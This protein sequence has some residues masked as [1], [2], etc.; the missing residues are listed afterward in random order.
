METPNSPNPSIGTGSST[1][2]YMKNTSEIFLIITKIEYWVESNEYVDLYINSIGDPAEGENITPININFGSGNIASGIFQKA[3]NITG[4]SGGDF[5]DRTRIPADNNNHS[6]SWDA[7]LI[8]P[9]NSIL[10]FQAGNGGIP[11]E[12]M[13]E[14]YYRDE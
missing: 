2:F 8:I 10:T 1:F 11:I 9:K 13:I 7:K 6:H 3:A 5:L 14:F 4:I 12:I